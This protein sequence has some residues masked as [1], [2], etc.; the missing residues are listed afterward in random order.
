MACNTICVRKLN[1]VTVRH[2]CNI[3]RHPLKSKN[4]GFLIQT[5]LKD[6]II[7]LPIHIKKN[8]FLGQHIA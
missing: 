5:Q 1:D 6:Y 4:I 8:N 2:K 7:C 3:V